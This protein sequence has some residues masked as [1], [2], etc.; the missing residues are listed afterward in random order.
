MDSLKLIADARARGVDVTI[1]QYP[2]T[3]SATGIDALLPPWALEGGQ[4]E[5]VRR[6]KDPGRSAPGSRR[7][8]STT[9]SSIGAAVTRRTSSIAACAW[10]PSLAGQEPGRRSRASA[11]TS[12]RS[13]TPPTPRCPSSSGAAR[14]A[15]FHAIDE[16]DLERILACPLTMIASDG[17][18][19]IFGKAAPHPRSYGTFARVLAV[20]VRDKGVLTLEEAVRQMTSLPACRLGPRATAAS[21][22]PG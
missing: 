12:R 13:R 9:S 14:A 22:G 8:S 20:Y 5:I 1:D 10:D 17:E 7:R 4:A 16:Q 19:P 2:Y 21:C 3:A 6:L 15:I 11:A 18:V